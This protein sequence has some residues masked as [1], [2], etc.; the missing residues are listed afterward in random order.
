[1]PSSIIKRVEAM[2]I[3]EKQDKTI[4]FYDRSGTP[5][6]DL[7]DS[8]NEETNEAAAGVENGNEEAINKAPGIAIKQH[9]NDDYITVNG[10]IIVTTEDDGITGVHVPGMTT[11]DGGIT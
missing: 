3:K 11:E 8:P 10:D 4:T 5:I 9:N 2:A 7:Y 6:A 1:M